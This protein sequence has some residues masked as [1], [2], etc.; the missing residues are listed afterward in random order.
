LR[1]ELSHDRLDPLA[2]ER[3]ARGVREGKRHGN[4][5][6]LDGR[7]ACVFER[8]APDEQQPPAERPPDPAS[9][10]DGDPWA[11][12]FGLREHAGIAVHGHR[13]RSC[14]PASFRDRRGL[15]VDHLKP[16]LVACPR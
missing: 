3:P 4:E 10:S 14:E 12:R 13:A 15:Q 16:H 1:I 11:V 2:T 9:S 7:A 8:N 6:R 5:T